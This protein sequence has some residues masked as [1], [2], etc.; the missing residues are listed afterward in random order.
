MS[1]G[2]G[3]SALLAGVVTEVAGGGPCGLDKA[4]R[5]AGIIG[6]A[7]GEG[8]VA[9]GGGNTFSA[10]EKTVTGAGSEGGGLKEE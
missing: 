10:E 2:L 8:K 9:F 3:A 6:A 5:G 7:C 1:L 4:V